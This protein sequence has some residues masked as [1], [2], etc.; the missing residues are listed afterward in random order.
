MNPFLSPARLLP[1]AL[2]ATALHAQ[3]PIFNDTFADGERVTQNLP[4]SVAWFVSTVRVG[5]LTVKN[6][7]LDLAVTDTGRTVWG[8]FPK[9]SLK[10]GE[11]ITLTVELSASALPPAV[12]NGSGLRFGLC[13]TNGVVALNS[14][15]NRPEGNYQGYAIGSGP[16]SK[17]AVLHKRSGPAAPVS[18]LIGTFGNGGDDSS[19]VWPSLG[20]AQIN[21]IA[22]ANTPYIVVLKI[23]RTAVDAAT[24]SETIVGGGLASNNTVSVTDTSNVFS[25]FDTVALFAPEDL[26]GDVLYT[27][28]NVTATSFAAITNLSIF[29]NITAADPLFTVGTVIGG[30]GTSG[31]KALLIRAAGPSL[32]A[33]GV[34]GT[35]ADSKL[36]VFSGQTVTASN[37]NWG[38]TTALSAAFAQVGAFGYS[39]AASRD[40]AV[41]NPALPAGG[42]TV[43]V[44]GV[45]GATGA[46]IAELYDS[47]PPSEFTATTPRLINVSVLKQINAGE[48]LTAGFVISGSASKQVLIR[49]VGPTL[50]AAPFNVPGMMADPKLDLFSGQTVINSSND[51]GGSATLAAAFT[52]VGAFNLASATSRDA[53][54]LVTLAPGTYTAQVTAAT[55]SGQ[56]GAGGRV[57]VEVYEVP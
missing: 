8:Y 45:G 30:A 40:A 46:V 35:L 27:R 6:G 3:S 12:V 36:D 38:G 28:V 19:V 21:G 25:N 10:I 49:A 11:S 23:T 29:T 50:S 55:S 13:H 14:D 44:S 5:T 4:D 33:L 20:T 56:V 42:Y 57:L 31:N 51:W 43:E 52:S 24:V 18:G 34:G 7:A 39:S 16:A 2:L 26:N 15:G 22:L 9:V 32:A 37:D 48:V 53:A 47:T 54:L 41:F 1:L 17:R